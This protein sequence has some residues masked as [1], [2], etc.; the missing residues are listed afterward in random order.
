MLSRGGT[1]THEEG[2]TLDSGIGLSYRPDSLCSPAA[3][4]YNNPM[5]ES[6]IS[7]RTG[8]KNLATGFMFSKYK[9][10]KARILTSDHRKL[11]DQCKGEST[12]SYTKIKKLVIFVKQLIDFRG[13]GWVI[14]WVFLISVSLIVLSKQ[15]YVSLY[16]I[17][18]FKGTV[19]RELRGVQFGINRTVRINCIAGKCHLPCPNGHHYKSF[20]NV[21]S[22][23]STF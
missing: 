23:F 14:G 22:G 16:S 13:A 19:Q 21:F 6:T 4:R 18:L 5:P 9:T 1:D 2:Q 11:K 7:P 10:K 12:K 3:G 20:I 17:F 15:Q 8:N